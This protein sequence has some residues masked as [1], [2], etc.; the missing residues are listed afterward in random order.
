MALLQMVQLLTGIHHQT[1]KGGSV[2]GTNL[3][4]IYFP[5]GRQYTLTIDGP[6]LWEQQAS[7]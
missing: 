4:G 6:K 2:I 1:S 3:I 5:P 7:P